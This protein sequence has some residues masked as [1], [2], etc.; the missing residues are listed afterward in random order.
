MN[1]SRREPSD[2]SLNLANNLLMSSKSAV[3]LS[4]YVLL[5]LKASWSKPFCKGPRDA[6]L[7]M[8][9]T[10]FVISYYQSNCFGELFPRSHKWRDVY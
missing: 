5:T 6:L 1:P 10:T 8:L 7:N 9:A 2:S 3:G 4:Q